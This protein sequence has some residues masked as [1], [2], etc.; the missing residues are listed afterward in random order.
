MCAGVPD[1]VPIWRTPS[2]QV[3]VS[4]PNIAYEMGIVQFIL[5]LNFAV[6][7]VSWIIENER[8]DEGGD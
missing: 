8:H 4:G 6:I 2:P 3:R 1:R 7:N 5:A